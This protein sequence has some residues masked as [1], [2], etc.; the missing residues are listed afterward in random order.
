[1]TKFLYHRRT[2]GA[3]GVPL[4][5]TPVPPEEPAISFPEPAPAETGELEAPELPVCEESSAEP[6]APGSYRCLLCSREFGK[7]LQLTRH[8]RFVHR[9][10]RRHKC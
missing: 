6:A 5:T 8:Q 2:H 3:G 4:P 9:L 7:A 10:E 1:L